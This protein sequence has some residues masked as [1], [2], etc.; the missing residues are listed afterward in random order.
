MFLPT[1]RPVALHNRSSSPG[2][3]RPDF[4]QTVHFVVA[5]FFFSSQ[6]A[7]EVMLVTDSLTHIVF[8]RPY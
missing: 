7:L 8:Q 5:K 2:G 3:V 6:D 1:F 4:Y